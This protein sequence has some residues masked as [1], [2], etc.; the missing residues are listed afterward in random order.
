MTEVIRAVR[1]RSGMKRVRAIGP[2]AARQPGIRP[3]SLEQLAD[4]V[5][6]GVG[7]RQDQVG[8][9]ERVG[10]VRRRRRVRTPSSSAASAARERRLVAGLDRGL[11]RRRRA[12]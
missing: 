3:S 6:R 8:L 1:P 7:R 11:D 2:V 12:R 5:E 4:L 10:V 9:V